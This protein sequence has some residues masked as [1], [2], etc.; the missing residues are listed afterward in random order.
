MVV[1]WLVKTLLVIPPWI[2]KTY[3]QL[4]WRIPTK[5]KILF[6]T[7]DDGPCPE[8]T[9]FVLHLLRAYQAKATFFLVGKQIEQYPDLVRQIVQNGHAIGNH[10]Y[11]HKDAWRTPLKTYLNEVFITE[12]LL[13][14]F[15]PKSYPLLF[16]PPYG[17]WKKTLIH[18]LKERYQI[19]LWEVLAGDFAK[20][21]SLT[22]CLKI[23]LQYTRPGSIVVFHDSI[24]HGNRM[25]YLLSNAI[26]YWSQQGYRFC[27]LWN[28]Y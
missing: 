21:L 14:P 15:L 16:R 1:P 12:S 9:P 17:H 18:S 2:Q 22:Q 19:I 27:S 7:F 26:Q 28:G 3:P 4:Q 11:S 23:L 13:K 24:R 25:R 6:L 20:K 5:K 8:H 10:T